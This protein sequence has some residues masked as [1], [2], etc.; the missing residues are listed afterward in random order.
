M[1]MK[2]D[3]ACSIFTSFPILPNPPLLFL[4]DNLCMVDNP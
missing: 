3:M 4:V 1:R 2:K